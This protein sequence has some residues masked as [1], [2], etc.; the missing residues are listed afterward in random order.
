[1]TTL[2]LLL[3]L[4][5]G[6]HVHAHAHA[7]VDAQHARHADEQHAGHVD[8]RRARVDFSSGWAALI[9]CSGVFVAGLPLDVVLAEDCDV[10]CALVDVDVDYDARTVTATLSGDPDAV[11]ITSIW[12]GDGVGCTVVDGITE[13]ELRAQDVGDQ[14]PLPPLNASVPWP[15]GDRVDLSDLPTD[16]DFDAINDAVDANFACASCNTRAVVAVHRGRVVFE[17]YAAG[18]TD[19]TRLLG[20]SATKSVTNAFVGLLVGEG[21]LNLSAPAPVEE[22]R[23]DPDD[24][25]GAITLNHLMQMASGILWDETPNGVDCL[26]SDGAGDCA[27]TRSGHTWAGAIGSRDTLTAFPCLCPSR[28]PAGSMSQHCLVLATAYDRLVRT[29]ACRRSGGLA[30]RVL[31]RQHHGH[32]PGGDAEPRRSAVERL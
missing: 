13:A 11:P 30:V 28:D 29:S 22:W 31:D 9:V 14:T 17:R 19:T 23:Q 6:A 8:A 15:L 1:M 3:L 18:I 10:E 12:R 7:H 2:L 5:V 27:G 24:P 25:R 26:V 16:V 21:R 32:F 4:G 20:W